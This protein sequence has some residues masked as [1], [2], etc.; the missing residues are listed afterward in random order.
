MTP[1]CGEE[2]I[3]TKAQVEERVYVCFS[4]IWFVYVA[5]SPGPTQSFIRLWHDIAY[6]C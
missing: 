6:M 4:F 2:I 1:L 5:V 3:S